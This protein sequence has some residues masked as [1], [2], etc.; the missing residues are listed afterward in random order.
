[1]CFVVG[2]IESEKMLREVMDEMDDGGREEK[3]ESDETAR[4]KRRPAVILVTPPSDKITANIRPVGIYAN[5][6]SERMAERAVLN[7]KSLIPLSRNM[8]AAI[9]LNLNKRLL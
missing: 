2:C 8:R 5:Q 9:V 3:R 1:M 6:L 4:T 7:V